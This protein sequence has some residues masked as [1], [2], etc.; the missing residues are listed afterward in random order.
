MCNSM[1]CEVIIFKV[2]SY[3]LRESKVPALQFASIYS[4]FRIRFSRNCDKAVS[5]MFLQNARFLSTPIMQDRVQQ[6]PGNTGNLFVSKYF[7]RN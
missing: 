7:A 3:S 1:L 5:R 2:I 4:Q 6:T